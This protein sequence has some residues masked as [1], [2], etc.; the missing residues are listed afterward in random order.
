MLNTAPVPSPPFPKSAGN[1]TCETTRKWVVR[2]PPVGSWTVTGMTD[3]TW[4]PTRRMVDAPRPISPVL[5]GADPVTV[6]RRSG[7]R[8]EFRAMAAT[9]VPLIVTSVPTP[10]VIPLMAGSAC[11]SETK[12][13][14]S[15]WAELGENIT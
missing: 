13:E 1:D 8:I 4:A 7:P 14:G 2:V 5:V 9:L 11:R 10:S 12:F 15:G 6:D 3:P